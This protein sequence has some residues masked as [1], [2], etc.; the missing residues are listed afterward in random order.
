MAKRGRP[1]GSKNK[2]TRVVPSKENIYIPKEGKHHCCM[3]G[4]SSVKQEFF[5]SCRSPFW[6]ENNYRLPVCIDCLEKYFQERIMEFGS[7]LLALEYVCMHFDL[8]FSRSK[9]EATKDMNGTSRLTN[10]IRLANLNGRS[11]VRKTYDTTLQERK[12][13][14][15]TAST[16]K[17]VDDIAPAVEGD[18]TEETQKRQEEQFKKQ[19]ID[20]EE[21]ER[22]KDKFGSDFTPKELQAMEKHYQRLMLQLNPTQ[23]DEDDIV[24]EQIVCDACITRAMKERKIREGDTESAVKLAKEYQNM[25]TG[26][27]FT[28]YLKAQQASLSEG[29]CIGKWTK[30]IEQFCPSDIYKDKNLYTDQSGLQKII[31]YVRQHFARPRKNF[32]TNNYVPHPDFNIEVE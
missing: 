21:V 7:D 26:K 13:A 32:E 14:S 9:W 1:K 25:I 19:G 6:K 11:K 12:Y 28:Q 15:I 29:D 10:Y 5:P 27:N 24:I 30:E 20:P 4:K 17:A 2:S 8:Y 23:T 31:N 22:L 16:Q 3:C 18:M